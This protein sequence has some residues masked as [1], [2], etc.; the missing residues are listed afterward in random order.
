MS[1]KR[2][3]LF[4]QG[5]GK[6]AHDEWDS[7]LVASLQQALGEEY[8]IRYPRMPN[9]GDPNYARWKSALEAELGKLRGGAVLVAHSLGATILLKV[10]SDRPSNRGFGAIFLIAAPF[11]GEGGWAT[12]DLQLPP[13]LDAR[14]PQGVPI[15]FYQGLAD[16]TAPPSHVELY[17]R[18]IPRARV[19]RLPGRDHQL[20]DNLS[21]IAA[22]IASLDDSGVQR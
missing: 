11:V 21:E 22:A 4:V 10:L 18:A 1:V 8:E 5:G 9:E 20:N 17:A 14:L 3:L 12:D 15:D 13:D 16:Q 6:G 2:Q 7:K 19:H